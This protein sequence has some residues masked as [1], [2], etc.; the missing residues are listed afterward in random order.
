MSFEIG[1]LETYVRR[2]AELPLDGTPRHRG[3]L[4][5]PLRA[6]LLP[7]VTSARTWIKQRDFEN[8]R[9]LER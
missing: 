7:G 5:S 6:H 9:A 2:L 3:E 1:S 8:C 4:R